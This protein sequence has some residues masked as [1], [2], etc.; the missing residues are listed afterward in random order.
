MSAKQL[1][2]ADVEAE[3]RRF[4]QYVKDIEPGIRANSPNLRTD[5]AYAVIAMSLFIA[6]ED[7]KADLI[8]ANALLKRIEPYMDSIVCYASTMQEF[9]GNRLAKDVDDYIKRIDQ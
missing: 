2:A 6:L 8:A 4:K 1:T 9:A 3:Q 5:E 7:I